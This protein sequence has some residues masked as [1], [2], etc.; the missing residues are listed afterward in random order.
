VPDEIIV[1]R[2]TPQVKG[3]SG[4]RLAS[5]SVGILRFWVPTAPTKA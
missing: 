2:T 1:N 3:T 5:A 4:G